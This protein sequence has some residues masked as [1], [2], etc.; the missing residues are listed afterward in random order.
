MRKHRLRIAQTLDFGTH[1]EQTTDRRK[2]AVFYE[3]EE[4]VYCTVKGSLEKILE[5]SKYMLVDGKREK[6]DESLLQEQN[7]SL[8]KD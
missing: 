6:L 4:S 3:K 5:F 8:A 1:T 2:G 7:E